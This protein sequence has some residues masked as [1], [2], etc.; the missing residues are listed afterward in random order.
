MEGGKLKVVAVDFVVEGLAGD[1]ECGGGE[2]EVAAGVG[3]GTGN[4]QTFHL[5]KGSGDNAVDSEVSWGGLGGIG[6]GGVGGGWGCVGG[7][8]NCVGSGGAGRIG[9]AY[10]AGWV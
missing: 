2:G 8:W 7:I 4:H 5:F 6:S 1:A 10:G 3:E 9:G